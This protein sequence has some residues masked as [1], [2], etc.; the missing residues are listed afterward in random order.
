MNQLTEL[1]IKRKELLDY[2]KTKQAFRVS[3]G[4]TK[5]KDY[6]EF[7]PYYNLREIMNDEVVIEFDMPKNFEGTLADFQQISRQAINETALNLC[8][9]EYSF[10]VWEHNGKSPH[11]QIESLPI[12]HL[13]K[14]QLKIFKKVFVKKYVPEE[15]HQYL[16]YSLCGVHLIALEWQKH[17][18]G[19]YGVK[20]LVKNNKI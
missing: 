13:D 1:E 4:K 2:Y 19:C 3:V 14:E 10:E 7:S 18:K 8:N 20:Q 17:W 16:D 15:Y 6:Q 5:W 9:A 12:T 11:L